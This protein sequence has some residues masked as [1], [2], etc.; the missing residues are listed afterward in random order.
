MVRN[1]FIFNVLRPSVD[2]SDSE[3]IRVLGS[4]PR[5]L[6]VIERQTD[7]ALLYDGWQWIGRLLSM[8]DE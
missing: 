4:L 5:R 3:C 1:S 7:T 8:R 6:G 2:E